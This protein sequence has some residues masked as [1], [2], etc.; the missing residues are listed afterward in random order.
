MDKNKK[1]HLEINTLTPTEFIELSKAV[2]W[3]LERNYDMNKVAQA[4]KETS[5]SVVIRDHEGN[6]L[7]CA[8]AF[9]DDL[10]MT[11]IPDIFVRPEYQKCG[12]GKLIIEKIK[13]RYGHTAFFFGA[14][15]GNEP[16][17]EKLGFQK[18]MQSYAGRFKKNPYY[19]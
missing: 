1:Y 11:F 16:F 3:G 18:S 9:S 13:E 2:G 4:I 7:G 12:I 17:F 10:F 19:S 15:P 14:Q 8:R 6:A 5:I